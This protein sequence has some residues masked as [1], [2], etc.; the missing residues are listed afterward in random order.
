LICTSAVL[1]QLDCRVTRSPFRS[2][3]VDSPRNCWRLTH[4]LPFLALVFLLA[5]SFHEP[6]RWPQWVVIGVYIVC[7]LPYIAASYYERY[8]AP[9][10]AVKVLLV[11][12]AMD[13]LLSWRRDVAERV[14]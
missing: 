2:G 8:A 11:V 7:L 1:S 12:W 5:A 3:L 14:Q 13:R 10:V 6:L 4:P 9:L